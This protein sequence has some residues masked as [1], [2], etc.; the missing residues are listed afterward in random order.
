LLVSAVSVCH[1]KIVLVV[2]HGAASK[3]GCGQD[4]PPHGEIRNR[5]YNCGGMSTKVLMG[6]DEYLRTSFDGP[7]CEYLDGEVVA[8]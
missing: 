4:W 2:E 5:A 3:G 1:N 8:E 7:D 6:V